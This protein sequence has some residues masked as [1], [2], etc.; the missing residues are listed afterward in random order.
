MIYHAPGVKEM[1]LPGKIARKINSG[2]KN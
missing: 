2:E 1:P